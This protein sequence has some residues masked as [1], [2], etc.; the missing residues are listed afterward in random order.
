M[1][2]GRAV[3]SIRAPGKEAEEMVPHMLGGA[4]CY[5]QRHEENGHE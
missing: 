3:D 5:S 4:R 2:L 1:P